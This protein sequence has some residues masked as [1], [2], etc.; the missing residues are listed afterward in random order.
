MRPRPTATDRGPRARR[1]IRRVA[2]GLPG[3]AR[4]GRQPGHH[5]TT[6]TRARPRTGGHDP[7]SWLCPG[8]QTSRHGTTRNHGRRQAGGRPGHDQKILHHATTTTRGRLSGRR[9]AVRPA[10]AATA[11]RSSDDPPRDHD[12][13]RPASGRRSPGRPRPEDPL[14]T[15]DHDDPRPLSGRRSRSGPATSATVIRR[16]AT[17]PRR[18]AATVRP[19]IPVRP[20]TSAPVIRRPA[21]RPRRP[22]TGVAGRRSPGAT[23]RRPFTTRPRRPAT[24]LRPAV[25]RA[26]A[27][28]T[29][30]HATTTTRDRSSGRGGHRRRPRPEDPSPRDHD[31]P[32]H[33][34]AADPGQAG[35]QR[36]G[37]QTT[38]HAT[39]TTRDRRQAGGHPRH[40]RKTLH[41]ATTTCHGRCPAGDPGPAGR[42]RCGCRPSRLSAPRQLPRGRSP[43]ARSR[44]PTGRSR[45]APPGPR[46]SPPSANRRPDPGR[47]HR[48]IS[49]AAALIPV[50]V[51]PVPGR[52][53]RAPELAV[54]GR[55]AALARPGRARPAT[56]RTALAA[57]RP[58]VRRE[59]GRPP[60]PGLPPR[61]DADCPLSGRT[62]A[63]RLAPVTASR[64][65]RVRRRSLPRAP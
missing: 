49:R 63:V 26:T 55:V 46:V 40:G 52:P 39:T 57:R 7:T 15:P 17:R 53:A 30:H 61:S 2:A 60:A 14:T 6:T 50:P 37:H 42:L 23:T 33:C 27:R 32:R 47:S 35:H 59:S 41:R 3:R 43:A 12:E 45:W 22:A 11:P 25:T 9:S 21:T 16:P 19:P 28:Q 13:P 31:D 8:H 20:A 58:A 64:A 1:P 54:T 44:E 38:R 62:V 10:T 65:A 24:A 51:P 29:F 48:A 56:R 34:P 4:Y 36:P 5:G 18:P